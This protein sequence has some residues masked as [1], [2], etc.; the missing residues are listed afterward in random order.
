MDIS[1]FSAQMV[2]SLILRGTFAV[3]VVIIIRAF[4]VSRVIRIIRVVRVTR[5]I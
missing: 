3:S 4:R 1:V 2:I 5:I